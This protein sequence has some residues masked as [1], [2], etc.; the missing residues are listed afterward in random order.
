MVLDQ[1]FEKT[2]ARKYKIESSVSVNSSCSSKECS[3]HLTVFHI[4]ICVPEK[5][6]LLHIKEPFWQMLPICLLSWGV[7][8]CWVLGFVLVNSSIKH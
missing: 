4:M 1:K 5:L 7:R 2:G 3:P 6:M 8:H